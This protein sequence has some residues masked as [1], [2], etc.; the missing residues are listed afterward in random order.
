MAE[1][2]EFLIRTGKVI[3]VEEPRLIGQDP[4]YQKQVGRF[5][6][7][8]SKEWKNK[9]YYDYLNFDC[10]GTV[11][12]Q[13]PKVG[14]AVDVEFTIGGTKFKGKDGS[15]KYFTKLKAYKVTTK[16]SQQPAQA[17]PPSYG[18][19]PPPANQGPISNVNDLD[20]LPF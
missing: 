2:T 5:T 9:T 8:T 4:K 20:S 14:D 19:P 12:S 3:E 11:M 18:M 1:A 10:S 16:F 6:M 17:P 7:E 15:T 13:Y